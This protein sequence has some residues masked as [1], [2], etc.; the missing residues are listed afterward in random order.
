MLATYKKEWSI[1]IWLGFVAVF[2]VLL[3]VYR[4]GGRPVFIETLANNFTGIVRQLILS[5]AGRL[6]NYVIAFAGSGCVWFLSKKLPQSMQKILAYIGLHTLE[7]YVL[8]TYIKKVVDLNIELAFVKIVLETFM[9]I[10]LSIVVSLILKKS[11]ILGL[12]M[13]GKKLRNIK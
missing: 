1:K 12:V 5:G 2:C 11:K 8:H 7:I 6:F 3:S 4:W 10:T 9:L 13:F